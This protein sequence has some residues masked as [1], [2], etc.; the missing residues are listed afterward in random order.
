M[1]TSKF[2]SEK[3]PILTLCAFTQVKKRTFSKDFQKKTAKKFGDSKKI[4]NFA[5]RKQKQEQNN[6]NE[7]K[8]LVVAQLKIRTIVRR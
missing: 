2:F 5:R 3:I 8:F 7:C 1:L 6:D 4:R